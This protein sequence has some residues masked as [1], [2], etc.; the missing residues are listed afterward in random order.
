VFEFFE[1]DVCILPSAPNCMP[2]DCFSESRIKVRYG[3]VSSGEWLRDDRKPNLPCE[4]RDDELAFFDQRYES[5]EFKE[6]EVAVDDFKWALEFFGKFGYVV[7][8]FF[9]EQHEEFNA[10]GAEDFCEQI[11]GDDECSFA[12]NDISAR[13][14]VGDCL[15]L[16]LSLFG[17]SNDFNFVF[18]CLAPRRIFFS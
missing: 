9:R 14:L 12:G 13:D 1:D 17:I 6:L 11:R 4:F 15:Y 8:F 3:R 5:I 16:F 10:F 7:F 18:H 2:H